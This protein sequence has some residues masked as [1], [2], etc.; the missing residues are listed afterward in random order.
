MTRKDQIGDKGGQLLV[1]MAK[2]HGL[3]DFVRNACVDASSDV[4]QIK[5]ASFA[6]PALREFPCH[7]AAATYIS[8]MYLAEKRAEMESSKYDTISQRIDRFAKFHKI[9]SHINTF[10]HKHAE[11]QKEAELTDDDYA[12]VDESGKRYLPIRNAQEVKAAADWICSNK[13]QIAFSDRVKM[14]RAVVRRS[15]TY[16][17]SLDNEYDLHKQAGLGF[18]TKDG[19]VNL[20]ESRRTVARDEY[21]E[22]FDGMAKIASETPQVM[23]Q[24]ESML[25][26]AETVDTFDR[27]FGFIHKYGELFPAPED[28]LFGTTFKQ[29]E[30]A[31]KPLCQLTTGTIYDRNNFAKIA[32]DEISDLFGSDIAEDVRTGYTLDVNKLAEVMESMPMD[33]AEVFDRLLESKGVQPEIVKDAIAHLDSNWAEQQPAYR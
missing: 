17:I 29:A 32:L 28:S 7:T 22:A 12:F 26:I 5:S 16:G 1:K 19:L 6:D 13:R 30:E 20:L 33:D 15:K 31:V 10:R 8:A 23:L 2:L 4:S 14:A 24:N 25:K 9:G 11:H 27:K 3:P 21:K 18:T